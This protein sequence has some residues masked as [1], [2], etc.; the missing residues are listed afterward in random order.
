MP[1]SIIPQQRLSAK[2]LA[3]WL[4]VPISTI[5]VLFVV[6]A[7]WLV[8]HTASLID[9]HQTRNE[10]IL[11]KTA[12]ALA[13][14]SVHRAAM[15]YAQW[16]ETYDQFEKSVDLKWAVDNLGPNFESSFGATHTFVFR[17]DGAVRYASLPAGGKQVQYAGGD[18]PEVSKLQL[19]ELKLAAMRTISAA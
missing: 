6:T 16:D 11:A 5:I 19:D 12:F 14:E 3:L 7:T 13:S 17:R 8:S 9:E 18:A 1:S 10:K 2:G 15:D 4:A